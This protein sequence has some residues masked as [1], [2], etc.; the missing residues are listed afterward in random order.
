MDDMSP[1]FARDSSHP[2]STMTHSCKDDP[3]KHLRKEGKVIRVM[4]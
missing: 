3:L 2:T 1:P 4:K